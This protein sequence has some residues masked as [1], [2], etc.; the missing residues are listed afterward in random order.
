M[1]LKTFKEIPL[2][3]GRDVIRNEALNWIK[4]LEKECKKEC[5]A[6]GHCYGHQHNIEWIKHFFDI[7][8]K[9]LKKGIK[10]RGVR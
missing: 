7:T 1:K 9:E 3:W 6:G 5:S 2:E 4:S 8:E 10:H